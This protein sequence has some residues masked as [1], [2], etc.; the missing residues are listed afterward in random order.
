MS[1]FKI[2]DVAGSGMTAQAL[3]LNTVSSNLANAN[4]VSGDPKK[5]YRA[6]EPVFSA[7][8]SGVQKDP[9]AVGVR[10]NGV[11]EK[12]TPPEKLYD[13]GNP[14]ANKNGYVYQSN[15]NPIEEMANMISA[16]RTYQNNAE[17]MKTTKQL[18][19]ATLRLGQ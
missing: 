15:V 4:S 11:T 9:S 6:R 19:L 16:S 17:V 2:F 8:L 18:L 10:V 5:A 12:Q 13:P 1:L 7:V 14:M 3:R